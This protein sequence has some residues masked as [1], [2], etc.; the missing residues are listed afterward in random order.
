MMKAPHSVW[1]AYD[2]W[3]HRMAEQPEGVGD[4][5]VLKSNIVPPDAAK[6]EMF[7]AALKEYLALDPYKQPVSADELL[8]HYGFDL[9]RMLTGG[10]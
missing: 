5:Y 4:E 10:R 7:T 6:L 2:K 3:G 9:L 1:M 8:M